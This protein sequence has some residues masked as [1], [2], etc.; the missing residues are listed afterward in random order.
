MPLA[1]AVPFNLTY[2]H[3]S[4][5]TTKFLAWLASHDDVPCDHCSGL[6]DLKSGEDATAIKELFQQCASLDANFRQLD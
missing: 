5:K 2:P 6:I 3:C 1:E 4:E